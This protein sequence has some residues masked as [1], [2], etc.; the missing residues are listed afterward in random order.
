MEQTAASSRAIATGPVLEA[1]GLAKHYADLPALKGVSVTAKRGELVAV[2]G[3]N[4]AGKT[5]LLS[6][7]AGVLE[8]DGGQVT[9]APETIGWVPQQAAVYGK[10]TV[11]EN[12][13]LFARLEKVPD[14]VGVIDRMLELA[15]LRERADD[16]VSSLSGGNRQRVNIALGL[17]AD[18]EVVLLDEPSGALDAR[19]RAR[20][21]QFILSLAEGGTSIVYSTHYVEE[22]ERYADQV[23]V[24]ADGED[25]FAGSPRALE[26]AVGTAE[27]AREEDF[28]RAF[29]A[30]LAR[31]G[32]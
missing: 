15:D 10:L 1:Q 11:R 3:P 23:I 22:A 30:F 28:E 29:V 6:I 20:L 26:D 14:V 27:G 17:L 31:H 25:L 9:L 4:G 13:Q 2:I 5:T 19:Q 7:L 24:L 32:H 12:I 16:P 18:P 8:P 21:W